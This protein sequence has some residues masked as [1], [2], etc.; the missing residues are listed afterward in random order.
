MPTFGGALAAVAAAALGG[1]MAGA[2]VMVYAWLSSKQRREAAKNRTLIEN[3]R[4]ALMNNPSPPPRS[5]PQAPSK[6]KAR[7]AAR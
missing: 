6:P 7:A 2:T 4:A 5:T 3:L 1:A